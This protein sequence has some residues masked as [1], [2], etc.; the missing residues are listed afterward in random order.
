VA[1]QQDQ[2]R[3]D[4]KQGS[5]PE[6]QE[7][8]DQ[9][10]QAQAMD[11]VEDLEGEEGEASG[12]VQAAEEIEQLKDQVLRTQAEMQNVRRR[13]EQD[14]EK[15]HK[16]AVEKFAADVL[17]VVDNLERALESIDSGDDS[18]KAVFEGVELTL[19]SLLDTLQKHSV[20]QISPLGEPFDPQFHEAMAMVPNPDME[21]NT[22]MEVMQKG[23]TLHGRL[24]RPARVVVTKEP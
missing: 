15:A 6:E 21:P 19:K 12:V 20:E 10:A 4:E 3:E 9:T 7:Q 11:A 24:I 14:V 1:E 17:A 8:K 23:Y 16:F 5:Q 22:V 2:S 13:A 18:Q